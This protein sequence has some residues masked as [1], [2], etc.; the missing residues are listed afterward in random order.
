M[1]DKARFVELLKAL[2]SSD[3]AV[4]QKAETMYQ[5]A[6]QT[7]PDQLV[8]GMM[9]V[10]GSAEVEESV[11]RHDAVLLR[12]LVMKGPDKDFL[13]P[14]I[15][16][17]HQQEVAA[18]LLRR[19]EQE[20]AL[21]KL[22]KKIG[23]VV[24]KLAEFV[25]D[26]E[27][28]RGSLAPPGSP[29]G[30]PALLPQAFRMANAATAASAESCEAAIRLLKD[31][32][33]TLKDEIVSAK[34]ELGVILQNALA[35]ASLKLR[36]AGLLLVCEIVGE[37]EKKSWAPLLATAPV[38]VQVLTQLAQAKDEE[39]LQEAIQALTEVAAV[40]PDFFKAQLQQTMEPAK[41]MASVARSREGVE[42][43][44]RN[45]ALEWLVTFMEKRV[46][47]ITK[48]LQPFMPLCLEACMAMMLEVEDG[49]QELKTWIEHM[50]DEEGEED[51]DELYHAGEEAIDRVVEAAGMEALAGPLLQLIGHYTQQASW[52]AK[53]AALAAIK[54]T[55]EYVE[56]KPHVDGMAKLLL[57]H[58][59]HPHPRVR[60]TALHAIGQLANDQAPHFQEHWYLTVMPVLL[61]KMDDPVDRV[62]A[63]AMSAFVSF[64]EELDTSLMLEYAQGFME[65]LVAKLQ[66][67]QHRGVREESITS[68]AVIAGVIE[69]DFSRYYDGIMPM[70][71]QFIIHCK[72]EKENRLRG[73]SFECMS[74]L[75]IAVG[76]EKFKADASE[77]ISEMMK[78]PLEADD[79]QREY[80]KEAS[81]RI[82]QCLKEDFAPFLPN[83]LVGIFKSLSLD[84]LNEGSQPQDASVAD[85]DDDAYIQV[86]TG[87]GKV[88][89]V[90]TQKFEEMMQSVQ[91]LHTFCTELEG[92]FFDWVKPTANVLL[93]LLSTSDEISMLCDEVRGTALQTWGLLIKCARIGAKARN[94]PNDMAKE[95]LRTG[96][97]S[98]FAILEKNPDAEMLSETACGIT[99]CIK[100]VGPG[101]LTREET[102]LLVGR[103]FVLMEQSMHRS[104]E[105]Q[106]HKD[107]QKH[108]ATQLQLHDEEDD[109]DPDP[110]AEE[111][112]LRRNY[113]EVLGG[114]MEV[115]PAE[116]LPSL[117]QC[118]QCIAG[119]L[120]TKQH[121]VLALYLACDL[122]KHLR[123]QSESVW[124]IFMPT[125][126]QTLTTTTDDEAEARTACAYAINLA[127]PLASFAQAAPQA[128][129]TLSR[130][131][132]GPKPKKRDDKGKL[133]LD[134]A[135]AALLTLAKEKPS[136]CPPE[137]QAW[138]LVLNRLP[139]RDDEDEAK[140]V[141]GKLVDL[142]MEQHQGLLGPDRSNL[143][144]VLAVLAE[145][146][147]AEGICDK[148]TDEKILQVFRLIPRDM[149]A[150]LAPRFSEKQRKKIEKMLSS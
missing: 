133:A 92:A 111:E 37:T 123:E 14:R 112:Q 56:E 25:C 126:F 21:P 68:I 12:R 113:E 44:L 61:K 46:K 127:A 13:F 35:H 19:F 109:D 145:V 79:V 75:G 137:I 6:K 93:P 144:T 143:P 64:G 40:E 95:L 29:C 78:T 39:L 104:I 15:T 49:E 27:D 140:T 5:Q 26:K 103:I 89:R 97:Q 7:E 101:V 148:A 147:K 119:W 58:V 91:L 31:V 120:Q 32:V 67:T 63:M 94:M 57:E 65:K 134:N 135:V 10:L 128:F 86:S 3:N 69:K 142:V 55:V 62:A 17:A 2:Q 43:G 85:D 51:E 110:D 72:G 23:E 131:V 146:Y 114:L 141:H 59:D 71:K 102:T 136:H 132:G 130:L 87:E 53:H 150:S 125:V 66:Q 9:T 83:L 108:E 48:H 11:R 80:I 47:W 107:K 115:A 33:P 84:E 41:F 98:T 81:E 116:F 34:Q 76:K 124:P 122:I 105:M 60:Y 30:W 100:N 149:L 117:P 106:K 74:L 18:E 118:S 139:L 1:S 77:A 22:Q 70:L 45:L 16:P 50:D 38:M 73:K 36:T 52:Q 138:Q 121:K 88:V 28:P 99:E 129:T 42:T 96:L 8:I 20:T 90:R 24:S 82:C 54:Q 4:R